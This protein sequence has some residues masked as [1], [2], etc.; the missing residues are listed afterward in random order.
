M[1][2]GSLT[3]SCWLLAASAETVHDQ[4]SDEDVVPVLLNERFLS[5]LLGLLLSLLLLLSFHLATH[6][7]VSCPLERRQDSVRHLGELS[8]SAPGVELRSKVLVAFGLLPDLLGSLLLV[9]I[10]HVKADDFGFG[11]VKVESNC[12]VKAQ[13]RV[14][15]R[16]RHARHQIKIR[17]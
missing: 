1:R 17:H 4:E 3:P 9:V 11:V 2:R 12:F 14:V 15:V 13:L 7:I 16:A 8:R 10:L 6:G 5:L